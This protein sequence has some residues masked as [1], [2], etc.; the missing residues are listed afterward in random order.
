MLYDCK[1]GGVGVCEALY[2]SIVRTTAAT[3]PYSQSS[4]KRVEEDD[5]SLAGIVMSDDEW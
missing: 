4:E 3:T 2:A 1:P 5:F